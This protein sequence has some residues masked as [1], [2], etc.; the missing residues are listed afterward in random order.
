M[1]KWYTIDVHKKLSEVTA[2]DLFLVS[3]Y[4]FCYILLIYVLI[5]FGPND[6][7]RSSSN[8][9][10]E[11]PEVTSEHAGDELIKAL[12]LNEIESEAEIEAAP[13]TPEE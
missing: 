1:Q 3:V 10:I 13:V 11:R 2:R 9:Q 12:G 8:L 6:N 4:I 7:S 5:R